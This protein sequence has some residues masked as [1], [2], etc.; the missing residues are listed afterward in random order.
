MKIHKIV[1]AVVVGLMAA[2]LAFLPVFGAESADSTFEGGSVPAQSQ[3]AAKPFGPRLHILSSFSPPALVLPDSL[4]CSSL[5]RA[6]DP[7]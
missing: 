6:C 2:S 7:L 4:F 3:S 5:S 1:E